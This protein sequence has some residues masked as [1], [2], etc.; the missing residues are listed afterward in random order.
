MPVDISSA[1]INIAQEASVNIR[2]K[3]VC[4][5]ACLLALAQPLVHDLEA[6]DNNWP[7]FRGASAAGV[8]QGN[9][10]VQWDVASGQNIAWQ[11]PIEGLGHSAPIIWGDHVFLTTAINSDVK[12]PS[13]STGWEGAK[14]ESA[15]DKGDWTWQVICLNRNDG[16]IKWKR[17]A[18]SGIPAIE[19]HLKASHANCTPATDGKHVVAF[20]G[21]EGLHCYDFDGKRKWEVDFGRLHSGPYN[22]DKLEWGF[23]SSPIIHKNFVIVQCDCLNTAFISI[24]DINDGKEIRRIE[25]HDVATWSTPTIVQWKGKTQ[26]VCNGYKEM[27]GYDFTSG[28]QLWTL[29][30]GGDVPVPAP[31]FQDGIIVISNSHARSHCYA[32]SADAAGDLTPNKDSDDLPEGL[33]WFHPRSGSY[34]PTPIIV[35]DLHYTCSDRGILTV[36]DLKSGEEIYKQRVTKGGKNNFTASAVATKNHLYFAAENGNFLVVKTG[37]EFD[38]IATNSMSGIVMSTPAIAGDQ[39]FVR[40]TEKLI[41]VAESK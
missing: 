18:K 8:A 30:G 22:S 25:R 15:P 34:M 28:E 41:C 9:P 21:S 39:L 23:A 29:S 3:V 5:C 32:I 2:F 33:L 1:K 14:G 24:L 37:R 7:Q 16:S 6:Q 12:K 40:T 20:F 27:A 11:T 19:R 36:R 17:D 26:I 38:Q 10:P 13:L 4:T 31:L 35:D